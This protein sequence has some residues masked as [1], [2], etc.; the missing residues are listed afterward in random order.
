M[1][2]FNKQT[3]DFI[4][5]DQVPGEIETVEFQPGLLPVSSGT[6]SNPS[7]SSN[8]VEHHRDFIT[9]PIRYE[10]QISKRIRNQ[11][12]S[13]ESGFSDRKP[14]M[15]GKTGHFLHLTT[16]NTDPSFL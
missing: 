8:S 7:F 2:L 1:G 12:C 11:L 5:L 15:H 10:N 6:Y 4:A 16:G 3:E 13:I 14:E 9:N